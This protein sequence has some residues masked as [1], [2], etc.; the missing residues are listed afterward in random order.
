MVDVK[1]AE[2]FLKDLRAIEAKHG[3]CLGEPEMVNGETYYTLMP[4][5][6]DG[7]YKIIENRNNYV[8]FGYVEEDEY[9]KCDDRH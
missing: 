7:V 2:S 6:G 5:T 4:D 9:E 1:K 8:I 3:L